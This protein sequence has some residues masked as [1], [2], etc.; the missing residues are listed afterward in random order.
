MTDRAVFI[1]RDGVINHDWYNPQ[2][3]AFESPMNPADFRL[4]D[5][6]LPALR[7]LKHAGYRLILVTNQPSAAK[8][9][10][11]LFDLARVQLHLSALLASAAAEMDEYCISYTHPDAVIPA[12]GPPCIDRKPEPLFLLRAIARWRLDKTQCWM[13]GDRDTDVM[14]GQRA[15]VRTIQIISAT[16]A[17]PTV[18]ADFTCP[19]LPTAVSLILGH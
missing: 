8:G 19:D 9:K 14:C 1:D 10:C 7:A 15:G 18:N 6:V 13:I 12:L 17:R 3:S 5:G 16:A 2:T 4:H 11:S